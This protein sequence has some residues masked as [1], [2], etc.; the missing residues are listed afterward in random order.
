MNKKNAQCLLCTGKERF[1]L[2]GYILN[3]WTI[4]KK[5]YFYF[6]PLSPIFNIFNAICTFLVNLQIKICK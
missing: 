3:L 1:A 5:H 4:S 2:M 6:D